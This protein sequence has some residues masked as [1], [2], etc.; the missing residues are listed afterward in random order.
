MITNFLNADPSA[1]ALP[2]PVPC[3]PRT[4]RF[5][6]HSY[7]ERNRTLSGQVPQPFETIFY[8]VPAYPSLTSLGS[9]PSPN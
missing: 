8:N 5:T 2:G 6:A 4:H 7:V 1:P 9:S 3:S